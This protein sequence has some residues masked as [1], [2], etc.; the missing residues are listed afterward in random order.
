MC[1]F[2]QCGKLINATELV[3]PRCKLCRSK[4]VQRQSKPV[5]RQ[6]THLF[7]DLQKLQPTLLA[8]V[9]AQKVSGEW[10]DNAINITDAW[11]KL[12]L[13]P[14]CIT[15]DLQWGTSVPKPGYED[16]VFYVW[17]DAPI[18]YISITANYHADWQAW[19]KP[20]K[21]KKVEL[22]QFMGKDNI[23][24]RLTHKAHTYTRADET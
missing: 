23:P 16:K 2:S 19:W 21:D 20:A 12:G 13:K 24:F 7:L 18:G 1:P 5:L 6:S 14:R 15:R 9:N 22:V 11:L 3:N 17:F 8:W 10:S 4:P